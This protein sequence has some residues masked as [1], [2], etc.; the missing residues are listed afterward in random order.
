MGSLKALVI[1]ADGVS[2]TEIIPPIDMLRRVNIFVTVAGVDGPQPVKA[3]SDVMIA[4]DSSL[5]DALKKGPYDVVILPGS[6]QC[7]YLVAQSKQAAEF[8]SA[9]AAEKKIVGALGFGCVTL[10]NFGVGKGKKISA[11]PF[12]EGIV[13]NMDKN[14]EWTFVENENLIFDGNIITTKG[15]LYAMDFAFD[16]LQKLVGKKAADELA[17]F[18]IHTRNPGKKYACA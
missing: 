13:K 7:S 18:V 4:P 9:H 3:D 17:Q 10:V 11:S 15:G 16:L 5:D 6:E 2:T 1:I 12:Y 8:V 14:K